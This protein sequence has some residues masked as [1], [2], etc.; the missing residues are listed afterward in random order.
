VTESG[1]VNIRLRL[2]QQHVG[3]GLA[4]LLGNK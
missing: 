1:E 3:H 2:A 4:D